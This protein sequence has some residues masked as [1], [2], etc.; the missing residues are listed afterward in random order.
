MVFGHWDAPPTGGAS[1]TFTLGGKTMISKCASAILLGARI[2]WQ[3]RLL[4]HPYV[5]AV[6]LFAFVAFALMLAA[7]SPW[8]IV[9]GWG[10]VG[11]AFLVGDISS[12]IQVARC[13]NCGRL[14]NPAPS[15]RKACPSCGHIMQP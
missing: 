5:A 8:V 7:S 12:L 3:R 10:V 6:A 13:A 14:V 2:Y 4:P 9:L 15:Y 1:L 11:L